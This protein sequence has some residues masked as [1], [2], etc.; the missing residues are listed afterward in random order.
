MITLANS[1]RTERAARN[2][3]ETLDACE[4]TARGIDRMIRRWSSL[5]PLDKH[6]CFM[7]QAELLSQWN[8]AVF[9][10]FEYEDS[11]RIDSRATLEPEPF[12]PTIDARRAAALSAAFRVAFRG[13][14]ELNGTGNPKTERG[15]K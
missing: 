7:M 5:S 4:N 1:E 6:V 8:R 2:L 12:P 10:R 9:L 13:L 11:S 3:T 14:R 15:S